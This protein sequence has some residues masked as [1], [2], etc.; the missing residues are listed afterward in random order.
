MKCTGKT[1]I[2]EAITWQEVIAKDVADE[3][4]QANI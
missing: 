4:L 1:I 3:I 2:R